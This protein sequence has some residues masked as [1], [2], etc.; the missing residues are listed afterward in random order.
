MLLAA[1]GNG[2]G[3]SDAAVSADSSVDVSLDV[4]ALDAGVDAEPPCG[5]DERLRLRVVTFNTGTSG[6]GR[7][8]HPDGYTEEKA[9]FSDRYY[10]DGLA[11]RSAMEATRAW[12]A[13]TRPDMIAFQEIFHSPECAMVPEEAHD[14]FVCET[15]REGD[16]TVANE[17]LGDDYQVACNLGKADKCIAV[18]RELGTFRGCEAALCLDGL[19]GARVEGCGG[20]SRIGRGVVA[21]A[22]GGEVTVVNVHGSSGLTTE[23]QEC[24]VRQFDQVFVDLD[25]SAG[26]NGEQNLV[27]GDFNTDPWRTRFFDASAMRLNE[28]VETTPFRFLSAVGTDAPGS[29]ADAVDIDHVLS[30]TFVGD[31]WYAGLAE[32]DAVYA[33]D[34]F[35]HRPVVCD[36]EACRAP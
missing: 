36:V 12:L 30:D 27:L 10:G 2:G 17:I 9:E 21:L 11:W 4:P 35:D 15:W 8:D 34:Y 19:D 31:C 5:P 33:E 14:G 7:T 25:G 6:M 1:C 13:E 18:R 32:R 16:P 28:L 26:A 3:S 23:D 29:Y 20:G 22:E 24:R